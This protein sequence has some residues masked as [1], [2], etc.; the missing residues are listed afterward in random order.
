MGAALAALVS[1]IVM[2][3][4]LYIVTQKFYKIE[5]ES[6][7]MMSIFAII[8]IAGGIYYWLQSI[9][10]LNLFYKSLILIFFVLVSS[11]VVFDKNELLILKN[12]FMKKLTRKI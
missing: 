3:L 6:V 9:E 8:L 12:K 4:G 1:Y 10:A 7:K 5:Y 11:M 2:A